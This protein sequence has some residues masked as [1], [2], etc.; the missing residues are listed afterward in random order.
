M[1]RNVLAQKLT[2]EDVLRDLREKHPE[3]ALA[4]AKRHMPQPATDLTFSL[5]EAFFA[6]ELKNHLDQIGGGDELTAEHVRRMPAVVAAWIMGHPTR[7]RSLLEFAEKAKARAQKA[8]QGPDLNE[9][10]GAANETGDSQSGEQSP[11]P[12]PA[13]AERR[14]RRPITDPEV[15]E[16]RRQA[17]AKARA[18]RAEKLAAAGTST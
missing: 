4:L 11:R 18:A 10:L 2:L 6:A 1:P 14:Q 7:L 16:K 15:L 3:A 17:L 13:P 5:N 9:L 12:R 8:R